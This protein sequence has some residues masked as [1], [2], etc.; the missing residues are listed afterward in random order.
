MVCTRSLAVTVKKNTT[1]QKAIDN[2]LLRFDSVTNEVR[3]E[4]GYSIHFTYNNNSGF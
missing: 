3:K 2:T 4:T 1:S